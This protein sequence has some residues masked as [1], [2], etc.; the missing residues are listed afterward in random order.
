[1]VKKVGG[2][3]MEQ[4]QMESGWGCTVLAVP[5]LLG[6]AITGGHKGEIAPAS[7]ESAYARQAV[8]FTVEMATQSANPLYRLLDG[9]CR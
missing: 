2:K 9:G 8:P 3:A 4:R 1:M 7:P 6:S 5:T